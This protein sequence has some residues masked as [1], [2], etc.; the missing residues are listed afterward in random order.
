VTT[1]DKHNEDETLEQPDNIE[2]APDVANDEASELDEEID[3]ETGDDD[4][5]TE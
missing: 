1:T 3:D 4:T 5:P 2:T